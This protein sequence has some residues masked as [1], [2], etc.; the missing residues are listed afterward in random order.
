MLRPGYFLEWDDFPYPPSLRRDGKYFGEVWMTVAFAPARDGRRHTARPTSMLIS[1]S[2]GPKN[3]ARRGWS[4]RSRYLWAWFRPSTRTQ[5]CFT[6]P[7]R[8][9]SC[10]VGLRFAPIMEIGGRRA[11][12]AIAG[13]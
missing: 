9:K 5:D 7:I 11:S 12:G 2:I 6:S 13:G 4:S 3:R 10:A 8:W 1:A